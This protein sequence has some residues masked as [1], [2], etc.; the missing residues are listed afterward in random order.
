MS[1][2][3][4]MRAPVRLQVERRQRGVLFYGV[5]ASLET[6]VSTL[7][8]RRSSRSASTASASGTEAQAPPP[9]SALPM[10]QPQPRPSSSTPPGF[11]GDPSG[12]TDGTPPSLP[13]PASPT[14]ALMSFI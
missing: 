9:R 11:G 4:L 2:Q 3:A 10:V 5:A 6:I 13:A 7:R 12:R 1:A 8:R 14:V